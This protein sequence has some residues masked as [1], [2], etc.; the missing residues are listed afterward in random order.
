MNNVII[1]STCLG[2]VLVFTM[3]IV[4]FKWCRKRRIRPETD[5]ER[6]RADFRAW[7]ADDNAGNRTNSQVLA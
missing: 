5:S 6:N 7:L 1:Y 2:G 3:S 4:I